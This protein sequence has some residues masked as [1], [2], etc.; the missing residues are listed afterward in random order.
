M[1]LFNRDR[2]PRPALAVVAAAALLLAACGD[3]SEE[4]AEPGSTSAP[5]DTKRTGPA[6]PRPQAEFLSLTG[7][8][9]SV[10]LDAGTA[11][12]LADN[13]VRVGPVEPATA[14]T[15]GGTTTVSFPIS[16]GYVAVYP[17]SVPSYIRGTFSHTGGLK[18]TAGGKSL[19]L[20]DFIVNPGNSTLTA[21]VEGGSAAMVMDLDGTNVKVTKDAQGQTR[22]DGT[23]AKLSATGAEA[24]NKFFNVSLFKQGIPLGVVHVV[25][26][27]T[28]PPAA[29]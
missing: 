25:L 24:L 2:G 29:K 23:V 19:E 7:V 9:T 16:E 18:F 20:T 4:A 3:T 15:S 10:D 26:T 27:G 12:I 6:A 14:S 21:T 8:S 1:K 22:L 13:K 11:K 28:A 5:Q 17:T